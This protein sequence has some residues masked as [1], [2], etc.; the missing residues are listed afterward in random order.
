MTPAP[1]ALARPVT[2]EPPTHPPAPSVD[3]R[4]NFD[5]RSEQRNDRRAH[6]RFRPVGARRG[7]RRQGDRRNS[8]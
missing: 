4:D 5:R 1:L 7:D 3:R 8:H 2:P 6:D